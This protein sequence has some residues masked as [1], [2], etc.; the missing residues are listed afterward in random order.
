MTEV[1]V[2]VPVYNRR[3]KLL[4]TL[5]TVV[6]QSKQPALLIVV[7][8]GSSDGTGQF[9]ESWLARNASFEWKV[10]RQANAGAA[11]AR[12][13]GFAAIGSLPFVCFL[14]SDDLWPPEF[15][16]AARAEPYFVDRLQ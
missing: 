14:D 6:A 4:R 1:A 11:A 7:D 10:I 9:A 5:A 16:T 2:V 8:D 12:N 15:L 3:S 13:A